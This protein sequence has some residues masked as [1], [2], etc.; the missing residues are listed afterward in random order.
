MPI[1]QSNVAA[2]GSG[3]ERKLIL[4]G[5]DRQFLAATRREADAI[6]SQRPGTLHKM[7]FESTG[8]TVRA[9][10]FY[11][12]EPRESLRGDDADEASKQGKGARGKGPTKPKPKHAESQVKGS[13]HT[14]SSKQPEESGGNVEIPDD[15][16]EVPV[17]KTSSK[18]TKPD[19]LCAPS[20][21]DSGKESFVFTSLA[22]DSAATVRAAK[23]LITEA[24]RQLGGNEKTG[25]DLLGP[26]LKLRGHKHA[27]H[28]PLGSRAV[29]MTAEEITKLLIDPSLRGTP[30]KYKVLTLAFM[31]S[32]LLEQ[33]KIDT[34]PMISEVDIAA[35]S[36]PPSPGTGLFTFGSN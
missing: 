27:L 8:K 14:S 18:S 6:E 36:L 9:T 25:G 26:K 4:S 28:F 10:L 34:T 17:P 7:V 31:F 15:L 2:K 33:K 19:H 12:R 29:D 24:V 32:G 35:V 1:R 16:M 3:T 22:E 23:V 20:N 13:S 5:R 11:N 21:K 30:P